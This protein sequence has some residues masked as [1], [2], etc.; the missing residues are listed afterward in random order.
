M[1]GVT[2]MLKSGVPAAAVL[3]Y[4]KNDRIQTEPVN[5]L[6]LV[7]VENV[8]K[9]LARIL[10]LGGSLLVP[11]QSTGFAKATVVRGVT[12]E[13]IGLW[14][15]PAVDGDEPVLMH[16]DVCGWFEL[17]TRDPDRAAAFYRAAF[18]WH[19]ADEGGYRF[20]GNDAGQFG[21]IVELAGDWEDHAFLAAIGSA[22]GEKQDVPPHWM[23]FFFVDDCEVFTDEAESLGAQVTGRP[24]SLHTLGTF[25][26][27][28]D[29]QGVYFSVLSKR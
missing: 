21:G 3:D 15:T 23:V 18:D 14:Q 8:E 24:E 19:I 16:P 20:I 6:P 22:R 11:T 10:E 7:R 2:V 9:S 4:R 27:L 17:V 13:A 29:P 5:W 12:G 25:A 1:A 26:V 28:R